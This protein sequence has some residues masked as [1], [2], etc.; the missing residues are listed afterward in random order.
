MLFRPTRN[1]WPWCVL[2]DCADRNPCSRTRAQ[3]SDS[4]NVGSG[5]TSVSVNVASSDDTAC[6]PTSVTPA[7]YLFLGD[8][9]SLDPPIDQCTDIRLA[10]SAN[11]SAYVETLLV[12]YSSMLIPFQAGVYNRCCTGRQLIQHRHFSRNEELRRHSDRLQLDTRRSS[13]HGHSA[14]G[15]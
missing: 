14:R 13:V 6:L 10:W 9:S 1:S 5:G 3:V 8:G 4:K 15:R 7:F 12:C 2:G 11:A